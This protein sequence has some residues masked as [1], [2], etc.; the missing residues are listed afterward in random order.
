MTRILFPLLFQ[1]RSPSTIKQSRW[2][3]RSRT[4]HVPE[5]PAKEIS[6][7]AE[8]QGINS[9]SMVMTPMTTNATALSRTLLS[10]PQNS[11]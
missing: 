8:R 11:S 1:T 9:R 6:L 2:W 4:H 7:L 3:F 5:K 10:M